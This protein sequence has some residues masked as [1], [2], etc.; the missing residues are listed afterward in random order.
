MT[1]PVRLRA[2]TLAA[3]IAVQERDGA[4]AMSVDVRCALTGYRAEAERQPAFCP[5][6][7]HEAP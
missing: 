4:S 1:C 2:D 5:T 6:P 3:A 7:P